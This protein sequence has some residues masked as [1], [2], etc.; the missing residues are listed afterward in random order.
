[1]SQN[2]LKTFKC[3]CFLDRRINFRYVSCIVFRDLD[4][5]RNQPIRSEA[6][7]EARMRT[8]I[9]PSR[10]I[11]VWK[12]NFKVFR[13]IS[14]YGNKYYFWDDWPPSG[15]IWC[16]SG[17]PQCR[18]NAGTALNEATLVSSLVVFRAMSK[19]GNKN[20]FKGDWPLSE[21][22]RGP[23]ESFHIL[24]EL[25]KPRGLIPMLLCFRMVLC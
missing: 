17:S 23:S 9:G 13:A 11:A 8:N 24:T 7:P 1:M 22:I 2:P 20:C 19:Y 21:P 15:T 10:N 18:T 25:C 5:H 3:W 4:G 14:K 16:P 6:T 12:L